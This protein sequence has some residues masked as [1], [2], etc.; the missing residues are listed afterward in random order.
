MQ[1]F[2]NISE[3]GEKYDHLFDLIPSHISIQDSNLRIIKTNSW[4]RKDYGK[5]IG[6]H[7][8]Q[9]YKNRK[10]VCPNCI[11]LKTFADGQMH[12]SEEVIINPDGQATE[13]M[14]HT[15]PV[16]NKHGKIV[17]VME[18]FTDISE[19]KALQRELESSRQE[20]KRLFDIVPCYISVQDRDFRII[21]ANALFKQDFGDRLGEYCYSAY[22][23]I[24]TI[25]PGCS[26]KK[27]FNDGLVHYR[28][29]TVKTSQ[30]EELNMIVYTSPILNEHGE[31]EAVVEMS[32]NITQVKK[33]QM[34][35][36]M[37]GQSVAAMAHG[38]KNILTGLEGGI[39]VVES[40]LTKQDDEV[41]QNGWNM[42][43]NN[44]N[45]VSQ[46][47][48]DLLYCSRERQ[49]EYK[50]VKPNQIAREVYELFKGKVGREQ[51]EFHLK[52]D[53]SIGEAYLDPAGL[54]TVLSNLI[55]NAIDACKFDFKGDQHTVILRTHKGDDTSVVFEVSDNGKGIPAAWKGKLFESSFSTKGNRGTGL[56]LLVS[57]K[58]VMEHNG[59]ISFDS[60][61]G[62]GTIFK[63][64]LPI[65]SKKS[66]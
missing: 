12:K 4:F 34:E 61:E 33:L 31:I 29:E 24:N 1:K 57:R 35:L 43:K 28:E 45:N 58:I 22:K 63:V 27:T 36:I 13:V 53:E 16:T 37:M 44:V 6:E 7:C 55:T 2:L 26:V 62:I 60:E 41:V 9:V 49:P 15:A 19:V 51:V 46:L 42:V 38:I 25:C 3:L 8:F 59:E 21:E 10:D 50:K 54:H 14:A 48:K 30:G 32:T 5:R 18:M 11:V 56:G 47:V 64:K 66:S 40:G 17:A 39:Y 52:L 20:Y 65:K 23:G